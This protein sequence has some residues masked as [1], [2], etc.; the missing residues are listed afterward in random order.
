MAS[1]TVRAAIGTSGS[2][3]NSMLL[4][5]VRRGRL[6]KRIRR[7][8]VWRC[9]FRVRCRS[10]YDPGHV[11]Q[12]LIRLRDGARSRGSSSSGSSGGGGCCVVPVRSARVW[13]TVYARMSSQLIGATEAFR[14]ARKLAGV[15][16]LASVSP[17]VPRLVLEPMESLVA[18]RT[19]VGTRQLVR[20]IAG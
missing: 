12:I 19:L 14:A 15:R 1:Q 9:E 3:T 16:F 20:P 4:M 8:D 18:E 6:R 17:N 10:R 2:T 11:L 7:R 13:V 5:S